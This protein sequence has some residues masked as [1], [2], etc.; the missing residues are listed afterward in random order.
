M[1]YRGHYSRIL[2]PPAMPGRIM[3][4][5]SVRKRRV[6]WSSKAKS[7]ALVAAWLGNSWRFRV[8]VV[9]TQG[10]RPFD[11]LPRPCRQEGTVGYLRE[12]GVARAT[13]RVPMRT[14]IK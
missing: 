12:D 1:E 5:H 4:R 13:L 11:G 2:D 7:L 14:P 8:A 3:V 6:L 10:R 9:N